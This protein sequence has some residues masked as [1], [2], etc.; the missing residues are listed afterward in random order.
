MGAWHWVQWRHSLGSCHAL[1]VQIIN[2]IRL[3][4]S[5]DVQ[6]KER[7]VTSRN[8]ERMLRVAHNM[9]HLYCCIRNSQLNH[10]LR[11]MSFLHSTV[12]PVI[13]LSDFQS[14]HRLLV[15]AKE[16]L[17]LESQTSANLSVTPVAQW[18]KW[19]DQVW[20]FLHSSSSGTGA[21]MELWSEQGQCLGLFIC[22]P[23][24]LGMV[25][26]SCWAGSSIAGLLTGWRGFSVRRQI[27]TVFSIE[28]HRKMA[29][30]FTG[31]GSVKSVSAKLH[32]SSLLHLQMWNHFYV[33]TIIT[34]RIHREIN[35]EL[36]HAWADPGHQ[37]L[38]FLCP[39]PR[40]APL[41]EAGE[42]RGRNG[43]PG[44]QM[45]FPRLPLGRAGR[46]CHPSAN[47]LS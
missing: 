3:L 17:L 46:Q 30:K 5:F 18:L 26:T 13:C 37:T 42:A 19:S 12:I 34:V 11:S 44:L 10:S 14:N 29:D 16:F 39:W 45:L 25:D 24:L 15:I 36:L 2:D 41:R 9:S 1:M 27:H 7:S 8:T 43:A 31:P 32:H 21:G 28:V 6:K 35:A 23:T 38:C 47:G 4:A 33:S 20:A 40:W 22:I